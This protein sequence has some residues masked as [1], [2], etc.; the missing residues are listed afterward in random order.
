MDSGDEKPLDLEDSLVVKTPGGEEVSYTVVAL[1]EDEENGSSYAVL[2]N[3]PEDGEESFIVTDP[4]GNLLAD[5]ALAQQVLDDYL[6]YAEE[7]S[8]DGEA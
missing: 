8:E 7:S 1:L 6:A 4:F 5:D 3:E 2:L